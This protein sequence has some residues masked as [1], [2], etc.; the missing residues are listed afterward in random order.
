MHYLLVAHTRRDN[1]PYVMAEVPNFVDVG[2]VDAALK[3]GAIWIKSDVAP[4]DPEY[5]EA[6]RAWFAGDESVVEAEE[7]QADA[8]WREAHPEETWEEE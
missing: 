5:G 3:H 4:L 7:A 1:R 2:I 6:A 8:E